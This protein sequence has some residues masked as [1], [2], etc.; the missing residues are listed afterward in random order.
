M[1]E[2]AHDLSNPFQA[3]IQFSG[4]PDNPVKETIVS[5]NSFK[6]NAPWRDRIIHTEYI[7]QG[8]KTLFLTV[9]KNEDR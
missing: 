8:N 9:L 1:G 2:A 7:T 4:S 5:R 6:S 3:L